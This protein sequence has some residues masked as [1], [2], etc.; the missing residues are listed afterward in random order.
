[1]TTAPGPLTGIRV[2]EFGGLIAG[3]YASS[4]L[5]QFGAEVI[6]VEAPGEGDPLRKWRKLHDGTSVWW[7]SLSRNKK[8]ITL[9][10]KVAKGQQIARELVRTAESSSK[11]S[12]PAHSKAGGLARKTCRAVN[13]SLVIVRI[14]GYGQ[15]GPVPRTV[16][17]SPR[18]P[19]RWAACGT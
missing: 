3:P 18:S 14:S 16:P 17:A 9:N 12:S 6:K 2:I 8:S 7:Y 5:A 10:L 11:T 4:I 13:P 19:R 1:M 15:T